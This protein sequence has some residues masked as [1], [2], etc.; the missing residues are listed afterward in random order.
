MKTKHKIVLIIII[1]SVATCLALPS[2]GTYWWSWF[3]PRWSH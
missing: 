1:V 2:I 3:D